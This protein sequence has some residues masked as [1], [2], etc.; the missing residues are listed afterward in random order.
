M[1]KG[2]TFVYPSETKSIIM[3]I[4][5]R[6]LI[7]ALVAMTMKSQ[8]QHD[9][10]TNFL[11]FLLTNYSVAYE[12]GVAED[13]GLRGEA[14]LFTSTISIT[15]EDDNSRDYDWT[16]FRFTPEFRF[17]FNPERGIDGFYAGPYLRYRQ[18]TAEGDIAIYNDETQMF[19]EESFKRDAT[20][21]GLGINIGRKWT[22]E[23][24]FFFEP[25][26]GLGRFVSNDVKYDNSRVEEYLEEEED[27]ISN[28]INLDIRFGLNVGWRFG[29]Q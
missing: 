25:N 24:G 27:A 16:G 21:I 3:K 12:Y 26:F 20:A 28:N 10:S 23:R 14:S 15:G 29:G 7:V 22:S 5:S 11:G 13:M 19:E 18:R 1:P 2:T 4:I 17:Y 9:V 6:T 8:A